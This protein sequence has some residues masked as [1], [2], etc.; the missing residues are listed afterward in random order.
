LPS[1]CMLCFLYFST[2]C[3]PTGMISWMLLTVIPGIPSCLGETFYIVKL[4]M[5]CLT[6]ATHEALHSSLDQVLF[7]FFAKKNKWCEPLVSS[8]LFTK[9]FSLNQFG[10]FGH[11]WFGPQIGV[12]HSRWSSGV[13]A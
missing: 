6:L 3:H 7:L 13:A 5:S 1:D 10:P 2:H 12:P 8:I 4:W 9:R 11:P